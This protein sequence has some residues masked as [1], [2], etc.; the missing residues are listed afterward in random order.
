[1]YS[2]GQ[3][4]SQLPMVH[5]VHIGL[6]PK[7]SSLKLMKTTP[8]RSSCWKLADGRTGQPD[9]RGRNP[10]GGR[11]DRVIPLLQK[12]IVFAEFGSGATDRRPTVHRSR[13]RQSSCGWLAPRRSRI[14]GPAMPLPKDTV[15]SLTNV[16]LGEGL[17]RR[18]HQHSSFP[19][20]MGHVETR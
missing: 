8:A 16:S 14:V 20:L 7:G 9:R 2:D 12:L 6:L 1:M 19:S 3:A 11:R 10:T 13:Q 4:Y 5:K 15:G 18:Y 17:I